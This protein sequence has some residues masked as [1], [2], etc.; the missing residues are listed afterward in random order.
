MAKTEPEF[1]TAPVK[2]SIGS[3][4]LECEINRVADRVYL[5]LTAAG[6]IGVSLSIDWP[7]VSDV[8]LEIDDNGDAMIHGTVRQGWIKTSI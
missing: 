6:D 4:I 2:L 1:R 3:K 5:S 8:W 7:G